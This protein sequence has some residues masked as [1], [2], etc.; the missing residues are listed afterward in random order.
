[1]TQNE[2]E[3]SA[4]FESDYR[5]KASFENIIFKLKC[6]L[7]ILFCS[8]ILSF[9]AKYEVMSQILKNA[10]TLKFRVYTF[11]KWVSMPSVSML[12]LSRSSL[13]VMEVLGRGTGASTA[14]SAPFAPSASRFFASQPLQY[15]SF[16]F[17]EVVF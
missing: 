5:S 4:F 13:S 14:P 15:N 6:V 10:H 2:T 16:H 3:F 11:V 1:M 17:K 12:I 8:S 7:L 9:R